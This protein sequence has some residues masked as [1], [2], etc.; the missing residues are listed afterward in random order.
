MSMGPDRESI[1]PGSHRRIGDSLAVTGADERSSTKGSTSNENTKNA[2]TRGPCRHTR[3]RGLRAVGRRRECC[4]CIVASGARRIHQLHRHCQRWRIQVLSDEDV[5]RS[6]AWLV[7]TGEIVNAGQS[8][9]LRKRMQRGRQFF[10]FS[11]W[12]GLLRPAEIRNRLVPPLD[13]GPERGHSA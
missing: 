12:M 6:Q 4:R 5:R 1:G 13:L 8:D 7:C 3:R 11:L 10:R 9:V 2:T